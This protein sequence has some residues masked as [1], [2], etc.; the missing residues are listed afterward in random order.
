[1]GTFYRSFFSNV[2]FCFNTFCT[3]KAL[4]KF[5]VDL[6]VFSKH[7]SKNPLPFVNFLHLP[8]ANLSVSLL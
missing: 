8:L 5:L 6:K 7:I 1:M 3:L 4:D 2:L